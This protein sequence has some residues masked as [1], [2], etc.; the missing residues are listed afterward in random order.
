[1][2]SGAVSRADRPASDVFGLGATLYHAV[3]GKRPFPREKGAGDS[4][5]REERF[6]QLVH[7]PAYLEGAPDELRGLIES[8]LARDPTARPSAA[9]A[10]LALQPLVAALPRKLSFGRMGTR[11]R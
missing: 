2:R 9:A 3:S 6:P 4:K 11:L 8:M 5:D 10:A 1:M 7:D